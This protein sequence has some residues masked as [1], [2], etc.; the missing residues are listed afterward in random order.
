[1]RERFRNMSP[2]EREK[3]RAEM[4]ER[5]KRFENM[6]DEERKKLRAEMSD[7]FGPGSPLLSREQQL[8]K[9]VGIEKKLARLKVAV[10]NIDPDARSKFRDLPE[11]ERTEL[12]EKMSRAMIERQVI[13]RDIEQELAK[14][15]AP[16]RRST[17]PRARISELRSIQKLALKEK[18]TQTAGRLEKLIA[19][20]QR[21]SLGRMRS[22][23]Q[24]P[25]RERP[26]R[27]EK[28]E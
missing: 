6:S 12:R 18:A 9:I 11:A 16:G 1:M 14:L 3:F 15:K 24:R 25:R 2:E 26:V 28:T 5:R 20:Y 23:E 13:I 10:E 21:E 19:G 22:P 4:E 7:R 17:D 8:A 27:R